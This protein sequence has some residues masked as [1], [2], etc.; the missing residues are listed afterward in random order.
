MRSDRRLGLG[1]F[2][3]MLSD[4]GWTRRSFAVRLGLHRNTITKWSTVPVYASEY[5][6]L[7]MAA[8]ELQRALERES[9]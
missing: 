6:R 8:R 2:D 3:E 9:E 5:L 1:R 7:A 4:M